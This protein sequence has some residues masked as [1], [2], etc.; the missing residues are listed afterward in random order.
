[1]EGK[2]E[3]VG[4]SEEGG[5]GGE[6][7]GEMGAWFDVLRVKRGSGHFVSQNKIISIHL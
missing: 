3:R 6:R 4:E 2:G 7:G 5:V 1:M